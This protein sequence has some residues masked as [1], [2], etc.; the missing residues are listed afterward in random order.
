MPYKVLIIVCPKTGGCQFF[1]QT[2]PHEGLADLPEFEITYK[3]DFLSITSETYKNYDLVQFH[4]NYV[5]PE[6]LIRLKVLGVKSMVDFDDYWH[7]PYNHLSYYQ[8]KKNNQPFRFIEILKQADYISV[9]TELLAKEV[10]KFNTGVFVFPNAI[11]P[12]SPHTKPIPVDSDRLRFG[13]IGGSCHL[14]DVELLRGLNNKLSH[15]RLKYSLNLFGY[16]HESVYYDYAGLL[17]QNG[18]YTRNLT[19]YPPLPV[20]EYL[21]FYNM[22]DVSLVPLVQHKFNALKSEL[23]L[24]EAGIFKRSVIVSNTLPYKPFLKHKSNCLV[25]DS[26]TDWF[27]CIRY[28]VKNPEAVKDFGR[29]L[30][31][32]M[33]RFF[34]YKSLT[35]YRATVYQHLL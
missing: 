11:N 25:A 19:L 35:E 20:P 9:T 21:T 16:K 18:K 28:F 34:N 8:Y 22:I 6:I 26:R 30:S 12:E 10:R 27:K 7:V 33:H 14:P 2:H 5:T 1:R 15:S 24:A 31:V 13:Y 17:T 3:H 32:D 23:K 29:Q 4:K